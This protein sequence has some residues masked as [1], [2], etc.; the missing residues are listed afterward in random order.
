MFLEIKYPIKC[1]F[2]LWCL[3]IKQ[4]DGVGLNIERDSSLKIYANGK[5]A[6]TESEVVSHTRTHIYKPLLN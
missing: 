2:L 1:H 5:L 4:D 3:H 6:V